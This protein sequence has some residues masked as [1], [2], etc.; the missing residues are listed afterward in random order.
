MNEKDKEPV[1]FI[2]TMSVSY[3]MEIPV[4]DGRFKAMEIFQAMGN[5]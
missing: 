2:V 3:R 4:H 1:I 5:I